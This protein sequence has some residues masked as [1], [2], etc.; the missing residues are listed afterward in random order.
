MRK[1]S[2]KHI[3]VR[4]CFDLFVGGNIIKQSDFNIDARL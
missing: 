2:L 4:S 1:M 3:E